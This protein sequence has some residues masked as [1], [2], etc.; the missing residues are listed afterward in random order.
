[1]AGGVRDR[2]E[3]AEGREDNHAVV[4]LLR[5]RRQGAGRAHALLVDADARERM[6]E[7]PPDNS[8]TTRMRSL[9]AASAAMAWAAWP[10]AKVMPARRMP[11][12]PSPASPA[13][14]KARRLKPWPKSLLFVRRIR[15]E[16]DRF[17]VPFPVLRL[18][19]KIQTRHVNG[20][21]ECGSESAHLDTL[22][23]SVGTWQHAAAT[24]LLQCYRRA[25]N[26]R[27]TGVSKA[28]R[29]K[30]IRRVAFGQ[31]RYF[32]LDRRKVRQS[33]GTLSARS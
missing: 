19:F 20:E 25:Q 7:A 32:I 21:L 2:P 17:I 8:T 29:R 12:T 33:Q 30:I 22:R 15:N 26:R 9:L 10:S 13:P 31:L 6:A 3:A 4:Y 5:G 24:A 16:G 27:S 28:V 23:Q 1:M 18:V 14:S 11:F